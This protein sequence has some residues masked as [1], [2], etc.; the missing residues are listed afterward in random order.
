MEKQ[1]CVRCNETKDLSDFYL[2][3][4]NPIRY[5]KYCKQCQINRQSQLNKELRENNPEFVK[6]KTEYHFSYNKKRMMDKS[7]RQKRYR[8]EYER[9][10]QL[11]KEDEIFRLKTNLRHYIM[12]VFRKK[13]G[14]RKSCSTVEIIGIDFNGLHNY[15]ESKFKYGMSWENRTKWQIDHIVPMS[16]AQTYDEIKYLNHYTN[17]QPLWII[18]NIKKRDI[19]DESNIEL[20]NKFLK[21]MRG[22]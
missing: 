2:H 21:E 6:K 14:K 19:I 22:I 4:K 7:Y 12:K 8:K 13:L 5:K 9:K 18:D 16:V 3:S 17:F 11:I 20:Y 15:I 1:I 10:K